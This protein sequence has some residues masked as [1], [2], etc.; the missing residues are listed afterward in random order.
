MTYRLRV[1]II[2]SIINTFTR[3]CYLHH[4]QMGCIL[5]LNLVRIRNVFWTELIFYFI[6]LHNLSLLLIHKEFTPTCLSYLEIASSFINMHK[7]WY[8]I[9]LTKN[10]ISQEPIQNQIFLLPFEE[11]Q[12]SRG[13]MGKGGKSNEGEENMAAWLLGVNTLKIQPFNLPPLGTMFSSALS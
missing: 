6:D 4:I 2:E 10:R 3:V 9:D 8:Y 7:L 1:R 12:K 5:S 11:K 13:L